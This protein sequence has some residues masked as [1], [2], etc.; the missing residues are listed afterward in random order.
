MS[1][2]E[3]PRDHDISPGRESSRTT[4]HDRLFNLPGHRERE[5]NENM[6]R[7]QR[8]KLEKKFMAAVSQ[9][10]RYKLGDYHKL[11][12]D[13]AL[14]ITDK[15]LLTPPR[16][17]PK[18]KVE[19]D[20][21]PIRVIH[22]FSGSIRCLELTQ[23]G[24]TVWT[25]DND[26]TISVRNGMTGKIVHHLAESGGL[27]VD[28]LFATESHMWVGLNDGTVRI[29]DHLVYILVSEATH[30]QGSVSCFTSTFDGKVFSASTDGSIVKWDTE[31]NSFA[32]MQSLRNSPEMIRCIACYG[33]NLFCAGDDKI[34]RCLDTEAGASQEIR[35]FVGHTDAINALLVQDGYLFS[36]SKDCTIKAWNME[37]G[38]CIWE[39][40]INSNLAH[41]SAV[42]AL[43]GDPVAHRFW[44]ADANGIMHV[45]ESIPENDF[46]HVMT[47]KDHEGPP[48]IC[49]RSFCTIDAVKLWSLAANGKNRIWY[50][51]VN[52]MEDAVQQTI[53][54]ME[55]IINQDLVEIAKW[56]EL[57][58]KL[59]SIDTRR[60]NEL[61][62]ALESTC[63]W[64]LTRAYLHKWHRWL[65][66]NRQKKRRE[67][68][69]EMLLASTSKG[70]MFLCFQKL[71]RYL[72][73]NKDIRRKKAMARGVLVSNNRALQL[74]Y[75]K[76]M[77]CHAMVKKREQT[78]LEMAEV[79]AA[80]S[81]DGLRRLT[82]KKWRK[83]LDVLVRR[84]KRQVVADNLARVTNKGVMQHYYFKLRSYRLYRLKMARKLKSAEILFGTSNR[85]SMMCYYRKLR[86]HTQMQ[87]RKNRRGVIC[88]IFGGKTDQVLMARYYDKLYAYYKQE[89]KEKLKRKIA[90]EEEKNRDLSEQYEAKKIVLERLKV[91]DNKRKE[92]EK[93]REAKAKAEE[94]KQKA[95]DELVDLEAK[96]EKKLKGE[97]EKVE[98]AKT[99]MV[100]D[101]MA[102]LKA[103]CLNYHLDY[104]L[105]QKIRDQT[106]K[107]LPVTK[108]F[109]EAHMSI[110]R[111]IIDVTKF[112]QVSGERWKGLDKAMHHIPDHHKSTIL[113]AIKTMIICYD[114]MSNDI[115]E[116]LETDDEILANTE[117]LEQMV[118]IAVRHRDAKLGRAAYRVR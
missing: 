10:Q 45:W 63:A 95:A 72:L 77:K 106:S 112:N 9:G 29:Y 21:D 30:H 15:P 27:Y 32:L 8:M 78:T 59:E 7:V 103:K 90:L 97:E 23:G 101:V 118:V 93:A 38:E 71:E 26:G 60:K 91:L 13:E 66:V 114:L 69:A 102:M 16:A 36:A 56:K 22:E 44:S 24:A 64:G 117:Y 58:M 54:G 68:I 111:V 75:W 17:V 14:K 105:I 19:R 53:D 6:K 65:S 88:D 61:S 73:Q 28:S 83:Y 89:S 99:E 94:R 49:L 42:T 35:E 34:I 85:G 33:Y 57:I 107:Q 4:M 87:I 84:K 47:L 11:Q 46:K 31:H 81:H 108:I 76:K 41:S 39:L 70:Q 82:W 43:I 40:G 109:L 113:H 92:I 104:T 98:K 74:L 18:K 116:S 80:H 5:M 55:S 25:G 52:K 62:S 115:K 12:E 48:I 37:H 51:A 67:K 3:V 110:K 79:I 2:G 20:F 50:S 96:L 100:E 1:E 86:L